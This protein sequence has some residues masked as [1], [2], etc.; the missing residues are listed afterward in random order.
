MK[1]EIIPTILVKTFEEVKERI[2]LV[3]NYVDWVQ[4]DI[5]DGVFV[6]NLTWNNPED[7]KDFKTKVKLE[8]H[9]MVKNPEKIIDSWLE[10]VDRIIVH[11]ESS[12]KIQEI[13]NKVHKNGKQI[14]VALNPETSIEVAKPFLNDLDLILLMSVQPG[15]GGQEFELEIL[16]KIRNLR[17]IWPGGNIEVDGGVSDK[18]IKEIFN[19]GANLFCVGTYVYQSGDIKQVINKLKENYETI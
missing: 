10:V 2:R 9:L 19:A 1:P 16:E 8:A 14:G 4:L 12:E 17:N 5:M 6:E 3:E 13:I 11:Y 15:K 18:N 7:L